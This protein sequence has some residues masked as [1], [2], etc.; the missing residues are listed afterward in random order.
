MRL[1]RP[2]D[3]L[4]PAD[5]GPSLVLRPPEGQLVLIIHFHQRAGESLFHEFCLCL[6]LLQSRET[7]RGLGEERFI[8]SG[9]AQGVLQTGVGV[10]P[11]DEAF[12]VEG[13]EDV[14]AL[15]VLF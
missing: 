7:G 12:H 8:C 14:L 1:L 9:G 5:C 2:V 10:G 11:D 6:D 15:L 4:S 13:L 3:E